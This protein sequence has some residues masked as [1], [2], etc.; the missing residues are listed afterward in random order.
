MVEANS[1]SVA[2]IEPYVPNINAPPTKEQRDLIEQSLKQMAER[3]INEMPNM[4]VLHEDLAINYLSTYVKDDIGHVTCTK[5]K[6]NDAT[7]IQKFKDMR[8]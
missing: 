3:Y 5:Y 6:I 7:V 1:E 4:Q 2:A 8:P